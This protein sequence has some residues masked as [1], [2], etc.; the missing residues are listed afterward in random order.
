MVENIATGLPAVG[1]FGWKSQIATLFDFSGEAL[2]NEMG[3]T[4]PFFPYKNAP[5]GDPSELDF[6]PVKELNADISVVRKIANFQTLLAPP[7]RGPIDADVRKGEGIFDSIGCAACHVK[8]LKA[9]YSPVSAL[10]NKVY[11]Y[12]DFL[13]H[14]VGTGDGIVQEEAQGNEIRTAPLWGLRKITTFL[15]DGSKTSIEDAINAHGGQAAGAQQ[16]F[17]NLSAAKK[18][19]LMDFLLSL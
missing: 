2:L 10:S 1:K 9:G 13:L 15:H 18:A 16:R 6:N 11:P 14:D 7:P 12:S 3:I 17:Q 4:N 8:T 5:G 19:K